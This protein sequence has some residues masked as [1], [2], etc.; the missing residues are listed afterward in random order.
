M[1]EHNLNKKIIVK[2]IKNGKEYRW[3]THTN[4]LLLDRKDT[5]GTEVFLTTIKSNKFTHR[6]SH[7]YNEQLY[8]VIKG[9]G[10]IV[11]KYKNSSKDNKIYIKEKEVVFI[12]M[13]TEHQIFS[14]GKSDL[15]YITIDIFPKG[16][17][18]D[19][20]TWD[21]HAQK[22]TIETKLNN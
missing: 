18:K 16:K 21:D 7:K 22:L 9:K 13:E 8:Y 2:N 19:E 20:K 3:L 15:V 12:P 5:I 17:P 14:I 11:Y 6:H 4:Y 10:M 1:K